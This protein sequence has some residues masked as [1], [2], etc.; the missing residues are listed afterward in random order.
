MGIGECASLLRVDE[1][2]RASVHQ[3][4]YLKVHT[5]SGLRHRCTRT[6]ILHLHS[7]ILAVQEPISKVSMSRDDQ[8]PSPGHRSSCLIS[9]DLPLSSSVYAKLSV[10]N[11]DDARNP[12][13]SAPR[14]TC[15]FIRDFS[16]HQDPSFSSDMTSRSSR[17]SWSKSPG[18]TLT[19]LDELASVC[20]GV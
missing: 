3:T 6:V 2:R 13:P 16:L 10:T 8:T 19:I 15:I 1:G 7:Q 9:K 18:M 11:Q 12:P 14:W 5:A 4:W 20:E 17:P